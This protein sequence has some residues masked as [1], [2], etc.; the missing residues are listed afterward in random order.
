L[1]SSQ[2]MRE[3]TFRGNVGAVIIDE[4]GKVLAFERDD[5]SGAWQ[6]PQG[7]LEAGEEPNEAVY[8]EIW[9]ETG[10]KKASLELLAVHPEWLAYEI[11]AELRK[12]GARGQVQKWFL[13]R[14]HGNENEIDLLNAVE[15]E[16]KAWKWT[17]IQDLIKEIFHFRWPTYKKVCAEFAPFLMLT[18]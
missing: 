18:R 1:P 14:F 11:P 6:F 8:R 2:S 10:I 4:V 13:F 15:T 7:G 5:Q 9:E 3:T 16:F 17:T 12:G